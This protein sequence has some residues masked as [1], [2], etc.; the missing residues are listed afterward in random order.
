[1][2]LMIE[3]GTMVTIP[4]WSLHHHS[5]YWDNPEDFKP[6]RF[7]PQ[8]KDHLVAFTYMPFGI[9]P[10]NCIGLWQISIDS[11]LDFLS[12][13]I[14][15]EINAYMELSTNNTRRKNWT[16][17]LGLVD[18]IGSLQTLRSEA[19]LY[20]RYKLLLPNL[21]VNLKR[22]LHPIVLSMHIE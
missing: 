13:F 17:N 22:A 5:E 8:N 20:R 6:Q 16:L 9:G 10:R 12:F 21:H 18:Q 15:R 3:K 11:A 7:L 14:Y 1:M 4:V 2:D 19:S